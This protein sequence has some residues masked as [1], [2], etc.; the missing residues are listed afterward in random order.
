MLLNF[1]LGN[2]KTTIICLQYT[3]FMHEKTLL[4]AYT[5]YLPFPTASTDYLSLSGILL[6]MYLSFCIF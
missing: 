4:N 5:Q 3:A 1:P 2:L 6:S